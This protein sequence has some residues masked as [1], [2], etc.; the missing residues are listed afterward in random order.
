MR[1][2]GREVMVVVENED[3]EVG[4][5]LGSA[6]E[7]QLELVLIK[8]LQQLFGDD[9]VEPFHQRSNLQSRNLLLPSCPPPASPRRLEH[10]K[11][12]FLSFPRLRK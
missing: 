11:S 9:R 3:E 4:N 5:D 6:A 7:H 1:I 10:L 12:S 2:E 8:G